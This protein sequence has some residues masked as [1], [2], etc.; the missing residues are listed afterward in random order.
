MPGTRLPASSKHRGGGQSG[1]LRLAD[2]GL[3]S[4][5]DRLLDDICKPAGPFDRL[6]IRRDSA[7]GVAVDWR[8]SG[9]IEPVGNGMRK[10]AGLDAR[11]SP[12]EA[13]IVQRLHE[14]GAQ[15]AGRVW[16]PLEVVRPVR[17]QPGTGRTHVGCVEVGHHEHGV[18]GA[19]AQESGHHDERVRDRPVLVRR[20]EAPD[21]GERLGMRE[22]RLL[23]AGRAESCAEVFEAHPASL[24]ES[25]FKPNEGAT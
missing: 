1:E 18:V 19:D 10:V 17:H 3:G 14:R 9:P 25:R 15:L 23:V 22:H 11:H 13:G 21:G 8:V 7:G 5:L 6:Q 2:P 16:L 24:A 20:L 12:G 4:I